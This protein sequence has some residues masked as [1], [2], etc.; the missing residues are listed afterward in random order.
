VTLQVRRS[1]SGRWRSVTSVAVSKRGTYAHQLVYTT[2]GP[3]YTRWTYSG[4]K[5]HAWMSALSRTR[6]TSIH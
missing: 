2:S 5:T 4:G 6:T 3:V 1:K